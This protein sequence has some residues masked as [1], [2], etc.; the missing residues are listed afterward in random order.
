MSCCTWH[1]CV[2]PYRRTRHVKRAFLATI[3]PGGYGHSVQVLSLMCLSLFQMHGGMQAGHGYS[4]VLSARLPYIQMLGRWLCT[5]R[6]HQL[7]L[8]AFRTYVDFATGLSCS[9]HTVDTA[10]LAV[11]LARFASPGDR[12]YRSCTAVGDPMCVCVCV[13]V[14]LYVR[15]FVCMCLHACLCVC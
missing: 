9:V 1:V 2:W 5:L 6:I 7:V 8:D 14:C 13:C 12:H 10:T 3:L 11:P 4:G 15:A